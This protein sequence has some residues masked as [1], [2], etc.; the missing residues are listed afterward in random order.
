MEEHLPRKLAAIL[1]ADVVG[2]S[3]L[4]GKDEKGTLDMLREHRERI[5]QP[6]ID[7]HDGRIVKLM[8]DGILAE[9][10]SAVEA[11]QCAVEFQY[12]VT[13]H[14]ADIPEEKQIIY[15]VGINIGDIV[16]DD[17]D[18]FGDGVNVAS[19]LERLA[20]P[21][22]ICIARNV[23][24]QVKE[25]LDLTFEHIGAK[26]VKNIA[27]P[28]TVYRV[29]M[30]DKAASLVTPVVHKAT[31]T[32]LTKRA[33]AAIAVSGIILVAGGLWWWQPWT[34]EKMPASIEGMPFPLP[35]KP[36]I[37]VLP[38]DNISGDKEQEYF[39]DGLADDLITDLSKISGLFVI[40][41]N[42]SFAYKGKSPDIR[43]VARELGVR[44]VL[45]GS[46][47]R[48][49]DRIRINAQLIDGT[50]GGHIWAQRY[51]RDTADIFA[52]Q[53]EVINQIISALAVN[54][55]IT[56]QSQLARIPTSNLE[57]Y[58]YYL[59]AEHGTYLA[60]S[61]SFND[62]LAFY[63]KAITIDP[64]FAEAYSG[65]ARTQVEI[66][67]LDFTN[68]VAGAVARKR[69]YEAATRALE[70]DPDNAR[71]YSV[72][73]ILQ[74]VDRRYDDAIKSAR[75]AVSLAPNDADAH[76]NLG[77]V[78]AFSGESEE[79]VDTT[80][81]ALSINPKPSPG[82]KT[83][84]GFIMLTGRQYDRAIKLLES[85]RDAIPASETVREYLAAAYALAGQPGKA[86]SEAEAYIELIIT[87]NLE[88]IALNTGYFKRR[89]DLD[90]YIEALRVAG[91]PQWPYGFE[92]DD[93]DRLDQDA[94]RDITWGRTWLGKRQNGIQFMQLVSE[95][96][97]YVY[98]STH[99]FLTGT[100]SLEDDMLCVKIEGHIQSQSVCGY[101]YRNSSGSREKNDEY[102]YVNPVSLVYFS[103]Q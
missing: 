50:S 94:A 15:R 4:M 66:W 101:L 81:R 80:D 71:A 47:R 63:Q 49:G 74:L 60:D 61:T 72:L 3:R 8:G 79:A 40:A 37:A 100:A 76:L 24:N 64:E 59:L 85:A 18:I 97:E 11:V 69:A 98:R 25:K 91:V 57:A 58:D 21:N 23:F 6:K 38:F 22:G 90:H 13:E 56:E 33:I 34:L 42:S 87:G 48:A 88:Y 30:D 70:L 41:R 1:A 84:A 67:R 32:Q 9:F 36:S 19:R 45:E 54:L 102:I 39:A 35:D 99:S 17:E 27:E 7:E 20:E 65:Y 16:V 46:V 44:Y 68:L 52:V 62:T 82:A 14:N 5:I 96:G 103:K 78:L 53:D 55:T 31:K 29:V 26:E 75:N 89:K 51:D 77:L 2:Y 93:Y 86:K 83:L 43:Q 73:G 12:L 92:D 10:P 28:I 95:T